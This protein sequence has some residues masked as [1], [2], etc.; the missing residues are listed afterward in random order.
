[1]SKVIHKLGRYLIRTR[2][3]NPYVA[4]FEVFAVVYEESGSSFCQRRG[5][6]TPLDATSNLDEAETIA[7]GDVKFDGCTNFI[8]QEGDDT[9][10]HTCSLAYFREL[11]EAVAEAR[12]FAAAL[13]PADQPVNQEYGPA[14]LYRKEP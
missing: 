13:M 4:D 12:R 2:L 3:V 5:A 7:H 1:M 8:I 10:A 9:M 14:T 11:L 6:I